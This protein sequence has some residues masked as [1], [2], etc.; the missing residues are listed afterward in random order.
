MRLKKDRVP[1]F[2]PTKLTFT[3]DRI[4]SKRVDGNRCSVFGTVHL[5]LYY[6]ILT[7]IQSGFLSPDH[8]LRFSSESAKE[9]GA[10]RST[11]GQAGEVRVLK[12]VLNQAISLNAPDCIVALF[13]VYGGWENTSKEAE[14]VGTYLRNI[15]SFKNLSHWQERNQ[16]T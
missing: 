11:K 6:Q 14:S 9:Y 7:D 1:L 2:R 4:T 3:K 15:Q 5:L 16:S 12:E 10:M 13:E 8:P